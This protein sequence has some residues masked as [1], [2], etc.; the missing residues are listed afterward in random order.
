MLSSSFAHYAP[1]RSPLQFFLCPGNGNARFIA[2]MGD[3]MMD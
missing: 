3:G 2:S 1:G